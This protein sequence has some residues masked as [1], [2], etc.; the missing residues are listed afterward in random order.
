MF[1]FVYSFAVFDRKQLWNYVCTLELT[2]LFL[3]C[4]KL[5]MHLYF[6]LSAYDLK[7]CEYFI[8]FLVIIHSKVSN[9]HYCQALLF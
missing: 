8:A 1:F 6:Q 2:V 5:T 9:K 3:L 4:E 7:N